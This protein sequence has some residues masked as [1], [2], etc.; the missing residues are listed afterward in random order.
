MGTKQVRANFQ[1]SWVQLCG[2]LISGTQSALAKSS[3]PQGRRVLA[4]LKCLRQSLGLPEPCFLGWLKVVK[5]FEEF[6]M[7]RDYERRQPQIARVVE[8]DPVVRPLERSWAAS[9]FSVL[10]PAKLTPELARL[11]VDAQV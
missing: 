3:G 9:A 2:K 11:Q 5:P 4:A 1:T 10:R 8:I 6:Q 7:G